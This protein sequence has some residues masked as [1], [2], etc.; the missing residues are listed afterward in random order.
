LADELGIDCR[1]EEYLRV[2]ITSAQ[3]R[4]V[5]QKLKI[6]CKMVDEKFP[7]VPN[8]EGRAPNL[9]EWTRAQEVFVC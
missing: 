7:Q 5:M 1:F 9:D 2:Y 6:F 4:E 8:Q 3:Q